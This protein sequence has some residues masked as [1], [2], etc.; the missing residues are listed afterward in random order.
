MGDP[1]SFVY[2]NNE[3]VEI[4]ENLLFDRG[5]HRIKVGGY[6]FHLKFRPENPDT[7]RGAFSYT[8]QFS[9]NAMADFLLG[10]PVNARSGVG[11]RGSQDGR[12]TWFHTFAQDDWRVRDNLTVNFGLRYEINQ[13]MRDVDN[14]L[15]TIDLSVP[16]GR[17][18]IASDDAGNIS[19]D[20]GA[21]LPL[22]PIP[23]VTSA[24]IGWDNSLLRPSK[25]RFAP[26]LGVAWTPGDRADIVVRGGYGVFL[27]Q[28]AY[29]VQTAFTRNLPFFFLKQVDVP[30][31]QSL[32][33][34]R[35]ADILTADPTGSV[36]G[37]I[38]DH[39]FQVEYTQTWSGGIQTE[40]LPST[41][42]EVFYMGSHTRGADN[43][44]IRNAPCLDP[45][46]S[47]L[48][49]ISRSWLASTLSVSTVGRSITQSRSGRRAA[50]ARRCRSMLHTRCRDRETTRQARERRRSRQ[51]YRKMSAIF[52]LEST[53]C[54]AS[55][56]GISSLAA[57][58]TSF[59]S[60]GVMA[61]CFT[62]CSVTGASTVS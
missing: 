55:I 54:R 50:C 37:D 29:S 45:D 53:R 1:T 19:P 40:L 11:G 18:V 23:W 7:A 35:T 5:N 4:Y 57:E 25:K 12:T 33:D 6:L 24:D 61:D 48:A 16:G 14:R 51:T 39:D 47:R 58:P 28:W 46:R 36:A 22:I 41:V 38:M 49:G 9:G 60:L 43:S 62:R 31:E 20:A 26:R 17:Y 3:H 52:F 15:S 59:R 27:N 32:P 42:V 10:Y 30:I 8:G 34:V 2:R 44:T 21:L 56:I 13:H